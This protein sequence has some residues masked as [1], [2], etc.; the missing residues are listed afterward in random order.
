[1]IVNLQNLKSW[2]QWFWYEEDN[3]LRAFWRILLAFVAFVIVTRG[4]RV[5]LNVLLNRQDLLADTTPGD[6]LRLVVLLL[7]L[8]LMAKYVDKRPFSAYGLKLKQK[9]FWLDLFVGL[10]LGAIMITAVFSIQYGLGWITIVGTYVKAVEWGFGLA[11]L[12]SFANIL[13]AVIFTELFFRGYLVLNLAE[14]FTFLR[15]R[16]QPQP[17]LGMSKVKLLLNSVYARA[18]VLAAWFFATLFFLVFRT[19][20]GMATSVLILNLMRASFLL[21]LPFILT[22][23][24][25]MPIGLNLGWSFFATSVFGL[26]VHELIS[27]RTSVLSI[28]IKGPENLTGGAAGP[29]AGFIAMGAIVT[30][31]VIVMAWLRYR[32][33]QAPPDF[34][35]WVFEYSSIED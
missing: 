6:V 32:Q 1:M 12:L 25:G 30:G 5:L 21:T 24:L 3:R 23:N 7:I 20:D 34:D 8:W 18:A 13:S 10:V 22:R 28:A 11:L 33:K 2:R 14:S 26:R 29:E 9:P 16:Y 17:L 31:G 35:P 27:T 19:T 4:S 15:A